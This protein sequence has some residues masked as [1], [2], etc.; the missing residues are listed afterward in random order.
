MMK[1]NKL[2]K[3]LIP[4][5]AVVIVFESIIL[6]TNLDKESKP[7]ADSNNKAGETVDLPVEPALIDLV[8]IT[9]EKEMKIGKNYEVSLSMMG[10]EDRNL[11]GIDLYVKYDSDMADVSNLMFTNKGLPQPTF[12]KASTL[13][14]MIVSNFLV[15]KSDGFLLKKGESND[16]ISFYVKPKKEGAF[17][18]EISTG[19]KSEFDIVGTESNSETGTGNDLKESV[20]MFVENSTGKSLN[21]SSN[22]L[23][24][25][26]VK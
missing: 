22:K 7:V 18:F 3:I 10:K 14:N 9:D 21:F 16:L 24:V 5:I 11:D 13:K 23:E 19:V 26:F 4:V 1:N 12:S 20:T 17:V 6:V 8:L 15:S 25:N 2:I